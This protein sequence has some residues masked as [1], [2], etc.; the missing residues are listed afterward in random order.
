MFETSFIPRLFI[1]GGLPTVEKKH[2]LTAQGRN[3]LVIE[4]EYIEEQRLKQVL[5]MF[6]TFR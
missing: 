2:S 5:K 6:E 4:G 1:S 3:S